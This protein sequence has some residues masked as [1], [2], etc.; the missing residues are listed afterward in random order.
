M[1]ERKLI[2]KFLHWILTTWQV[3]ISSGQDCWYVNGEEKTH[4][5]LYDLF[6]FYTAYENSTI[7]PTTQQMPKGS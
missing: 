6:I 1:S 7:I 4:S 2:T 3:T 5:Q